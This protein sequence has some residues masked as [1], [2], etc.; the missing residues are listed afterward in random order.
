MAKSNHNS[1]PTAGQIL[2][3]KG[4]SAAHHPQPEIKE[5]PEM[6]KIIC[7]SMIH[8]IS[9]ANANHSRKKCVKFNQI[10]IYM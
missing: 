5:K 2:S 1:S 7:D 9:L 10:Q 4:K 6:Q 8:L 3:S